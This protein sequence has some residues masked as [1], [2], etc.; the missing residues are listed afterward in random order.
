M[1][2]L[3]IWRVKF[4]S[5]VKCRPLVKICSLFVLLSVH[6]SH[7]VRLWLF[8]TPEIAACQASLSITNSQSFLRLMSIETVLPSKYLILCC[9]PSPPA[10]NL[11]QHQDFLQSQFFTSG[12]Q[13]I[14]ESASAS[15][16]PMNIQDWFPSGLTGL[17]SLQSMG[18]SRVF[19]NTTVQSISS[20]ALSF[21]CS[22]TLTPVHDYWKKKIV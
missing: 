2:Q 7:S 17:I 20:S 8:A 11:S 13:N 14:E 6:F 9:L 18:L 1:N 16:L 5:H 15:I 19:S 4:D 22:P 3:I 21:L 12:G 10:I